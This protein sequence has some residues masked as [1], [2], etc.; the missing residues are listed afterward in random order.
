MSLLAIRFWLVPKVFPKLTP[1]LCVFVGGVVQYEGH[2][3]HS[4][5]L[6]TKPAIQP[7]DAVIALKKHLG[8][9]MIPDVKSREDNPVLYIIPNVCRE[10]VVYIK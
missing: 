8:H 10:C 9:N 6:N 7:S 5:S 1:C 3:A 4:I 2:I